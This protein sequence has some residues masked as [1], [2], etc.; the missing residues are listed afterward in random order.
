VKFDPTVGSEIRKTRPAVVISSDSIGK[1]PIKLVAPMTEWKDAFRSCA[2][3]VRIDP[4]VS[5]GLA[6]SSAADVLQLRGVD[7]V[8]FVSRIGHLA[9]AQVTRIAAAVGVAVQVP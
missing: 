8:R 6:K 5:N 3:L 4:D 2:W 9:P 7:T 1:L